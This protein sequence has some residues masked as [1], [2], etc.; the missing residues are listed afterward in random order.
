MD[1][2][3]TESRGVDAP[4][5]ANESV[6]ARVSGKKFLGW[7]P[8]WNFGAVFSGCCSG[9][10]LVVVALGLGLVALGVGGLLPVVFSLLVLFLFCGVRAL[11]NTGPETRPRKKGHR[12]QNRQ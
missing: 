6:D 2:N 8:K 12:H 5:P 9:R 1:E 11:K 3:G 7:T 4:V 10:L